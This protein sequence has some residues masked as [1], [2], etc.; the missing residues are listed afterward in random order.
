VLKVQ[1]TAEH[2]DT[3]IE[4]DVLR[5]G[6]YALL[7]AL[8]ASPPSDETLKYLSTLQSDDT[9]VGKAFGELATAASATSAD[10]VEDEYNALMIGITQGELIPFASHYLTGFLCEQPLAN[11]RGDM[12]LM[13]IARGDDVSEP[14]DH[15]A[16]IM[17]MMNGLILG[18]FD[19]TADLAAQKKFFD[20]HLAPW[21]NK[22]FEDLQ[23]AEAAVFYRPV[24]SVGRAFLAIEKDAFDMD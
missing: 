14:E 4:E 18:N 10:A 24:G 16:S 19:V 1:T 12:A 23:T 8:L 21:A 9:D 15:I 5:A 6:F 17:E 11:L 13:G 3:V 20:A 22:F 2:D 7:S